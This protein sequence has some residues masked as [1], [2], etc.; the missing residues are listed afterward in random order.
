MASRTRREARPSASSFSSLAPR[1]DD[2]ALTSLSS[3]RRASS[4]VTKPSEPGGVNDGHG[5]RERGVRARARHGPAEEVLR[6]RPRSP[7]SSPRTYSFASAAASTLNSL[8]LYAARVKPSVAS[9]LWPAPVH[10]RGHPRVAE[11]GALREL[12]V[13]RER[14]EAIERARGS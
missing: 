1:S 13:G 10:G 11:V 4:V 9:P 6:L 8:A 3:A 2:R 14:A 12:H 7:A 5:A